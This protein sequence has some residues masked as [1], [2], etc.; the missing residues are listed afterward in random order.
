[1]KKIIS[2]I[3]SDAAHKREEQEGMNREELQ[4]R[5]V[6]SYLQEKRKNEEDDEDGESKSA[7]KV[8]KEAK[9]KAKNSFEE[10][11][12]KLLTKEKVIELGN[13]VMLKKGKGGEEKSCSNKK[14]KKEK[15]KEEKEE[16]VNRKKEEIVFAGKE[17]KTMASG[18][19]DE[20]NV[21]KQK[22]EQT[23]SLETSTCSRKRKRQADESENCNVGI[24]T[25]KPKN[26]KAKDLLASGLNPITGK[27]L[28][29]RSKEAYA[30]R[31][32]RYLA[33]KKLDSRNNR[34]QE[35]FKKIKGQATPET[36]LHSY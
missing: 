22:S 24:L 16:D 2:A 35:E 7:K 20:G 11:L 12:K 14:K 3:L 1:M 33:V 26:A 4:K 17:S 30:R 6:K 34:A 23:E 28:K 32:A 21:V 18:D 19:L 15:E 5:A 36:S 31:R 8:R 29:K 27:K 13:V 9:K 25:T 10:S